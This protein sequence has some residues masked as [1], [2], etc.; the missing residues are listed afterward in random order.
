MTSGAGMNTQVAGQDDAGWRNTILAAIANYIDA[1]SIVA[2]AA[3]LSIWVERYHL[4][5]HFV[6][7]L[8]AIGANAISAGIGAI[9]GG[10]LC[11]MFGRKKIYLA[12]MAFYAIGMLWLVFA[13]TPWMI[14]V[15]FIQVGLAVG[16]AVPASWSL[17]ADQ[18]P[19][20]ARGQRSG[21]AQVLWYFGP[22]VVLLMSLALMPLG[23]LGARIVFAHLAIL[24]VV[25]MLLRSRMSESER[26]IAA[27][28]AAGSDSAKRP[29]AGELLRAKHLKS[30]AFL[31]GMYGAWNLWAGTNGFFLPYILHTVGAQT[32]AASVAFQALSFVVGILSIIFVFMRLSD[33]VNQ[34]LM[35]ITASLIGIAGMSCLAL[36]PLTTPV[37]FIYVVLTSFGGGFGAQPF[38][39]LWSAELFPTLLRSTAQGIAF[40]V[41]RI[42]LGF[43]SFFVPVLTATGF[44]TLAWLLTGFLAVSA[45]IGAIWAPRNEGKSLEQIQAEI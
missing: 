2:G 23:L 25:L 18:A 32:Q 13:V 34:R 5:T 7:V 41:V 45:L 24:A 9:I 28:V 26:W 19:Q 11:D 16:A 33:R 8:G 38:F 3:T 39:Q 37:A 1:G 31:I 6:G 35:F 15:G 30:M 44:T 27:K 36:F 42:G 29:G 12:N 20:G 17:I 40:A 4:S 21:L 10:R 43:W 22:V 14:V